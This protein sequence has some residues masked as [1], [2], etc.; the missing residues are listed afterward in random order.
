MA[1][2]GGLGQA[3]GSRG[4]DVEREIVDRGIAALAGAERLAG[5]ALDVEIDARKG[6]SIFLP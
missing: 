5:I 6:A 3:G 1:D 2:F 4:V